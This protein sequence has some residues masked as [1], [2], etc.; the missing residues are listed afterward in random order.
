MTGVVAATPAMAPLARGRYLARPVESPADLDAAQRLRYRAFR[1]SEPGEGLDRDAFD[2]C[3]RHVLVEDRAS[4]AVVCCFRL[5]SLPDGRAIGSS[6]AARFYD[7]SA[8]ERF[9]APMAEVGRFC[10]DPDRTDPDI[11]RLAWGMLTAEVDRAGIALLFGCSSFRGTDPA[12]YEDAFGLLRGHHLAPA[13]WRPQVRAPRIHDFTRLA[14]DAPDRRRAL[15]QMPPLL[16][17]YLQMGGWVSD[18]AVIDE[19]LGTLHVFTGLEIARVPP[20]RARLL[21]M[22][23]G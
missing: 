15:S 14:C 1:G 2:G 11:L 5:L 16:R 13:R 9:G 20:A 4:G 7:L 19:D 12:A 23:A 6:Y 21:R 10:I 18:H 3:C 17:S 22:L 8:L